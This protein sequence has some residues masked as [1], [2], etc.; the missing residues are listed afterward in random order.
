VKH[1][2]NFHEKLNKATPSAFLV[3][4][5]IFFVYFL[6][7]SGNLGSSGNFFQKCLC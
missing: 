1:F 3:L 7:N 5:G 4:E 6:H 2:I